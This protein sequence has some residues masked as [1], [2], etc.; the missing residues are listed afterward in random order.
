[1]KEEIKRAKSTGVA[2]HQI[3]TGISIW[4][5][6]AVE[7]HRVCQGLLSAIK[8]EVEMMVGDTEGVYIRVALLIPDPNGDPNLLVFCRSDEDRPTDITYPRESVLVWKAMKSQHWEYEP[9]FVADASKPYRCVLAYPI[10]FSPPGGNLLAL[11]GVSID[12]ERGNHFDG[13]GNKLETRLIPYRSLLQ[14]ALICNV[15]RAE[16]VAHASS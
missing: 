6:S 11:G 3:A 16:G 10:I 9:N 5:N 8:S 14:L 1:M 2:V 7:L 12:S 15:K 13:L 4:S